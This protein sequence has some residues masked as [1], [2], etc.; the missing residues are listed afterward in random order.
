MPYEAHVKELAEIEGFDPAVFV[1]DASTPQ[2]VCDFVLAL[3][4]VYNDLHDSIL[5]LQLHRE[6][7][8]PDLFVQDR[9]VGS[10]GGLFTSLLRAHFG[11]VNELLALIEDN[12]VV[13]QHPSFLKLIHR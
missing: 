9:A 13:V 10:W 4:L 1:G 3:A 11:I 2:A 7:Q 6:N 5:G 12:S 8:P